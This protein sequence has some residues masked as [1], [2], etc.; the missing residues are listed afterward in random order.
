M[1]VMLT[2]W[3]GKTMRIAILIAAVVALQQDA[4]SAQPLNPDAEHAGQLEREGK[5][6]KALVEYKLYLAEHPQ[7]VPVARRFLGL[8]YREKRYDELIKA[9]GVLPSDLQDQR[10]FTALVGRAYLNL[11]QKDDGI[12]VFFS[13][14]ANENGS[15]NS[16][17]YVGN[18]FLSLG[19]ID[20][21]KEVFGKGRKQWG[22]RSFSR[23]LYHCF[24]R[25]QDR[26]GAFRE[27]LHLY[28]AEKVSKEW[29]KRELNTLIGK[30]ET[31]L[32]YLE[33]IVR[34]ESEYG[35]LAGELFLEHGEIELAKEFLLHVL[36]TES[37]LAFAALCIEKGY[38]PE[39]EEVL[40][41]IVDECENTF[42]E[43]QAHMLLARAHRETG[44]I[45]DALKALDFV[46]KEGR[47]FRDS[48]MVKKAEVL[49]YDKNMYE[50]STALL[51]HLLE[52]NKTLAQRDWFLTLIFVGYLRMGD[53]A[54]AESLVSAPITPL[55]FFFSGEVLFLNGS[56]E[57]SHDRYKSAVAR[58]LDRDFANDAL[59]R[60]MLM[61]SLKSR[62]ALLSLV[63]DIEMAITQAL[64]EQAIELIHGGFDDFGEKE[65]R[66]VLL[67]SKARAHAHQGSVNEAISSYLN[68]VDES[69]Q[70]AFAPKALYHAAVLYRDEIGD[71]TMASEL[72]RRIIFDYPESIEAELSRR[73][74]QVL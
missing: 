40:R 24:M 7:D 20:E 3:M 52:K 21:A 5:I 49:L 29:V 46:I 69:S 2:K 32:H 50:E 56:Y 66:V 71:A 53:L 70:S 36:D 47:A 67:Y 27:L 42:I 17:R 4:V 48:A 15:L 45:E 61:E 14:I 34:N 35:T 38:L 57:A 41:R 22:K 18:T 10:D 25:A 74:L 11:G 58:G 64:Y 68:V 19:Y 1:L 59:G 12:E 73:E 44:R 39:A 26:K 60:I 37:L 28:L 55:S 13:I 16:Y 31:L 43:E 63:K 54:R 8:L 51:E 62:P 33:S 9:Y 30:D 72:L 23:E 6:E 65:E